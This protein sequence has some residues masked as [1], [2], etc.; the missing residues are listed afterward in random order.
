MSTA[1]DEGVRP[2]PAPARTALFFKVP[3]RSPRRILVVEFNPYQILAAE[4][5]RS[6]RGEFVLE[7]AAEFERGDTAGFSAWLEAGN[8]LGKYR[9]TAL[10]SLV[11]LR[12]IVQRENVQPAL[13]A[14]TGYLEELV[15][16]Q[17]KGRFLTATPF[18]VMRE[19]AWAFSTVNAVDG[20]PLPP[21]G[22][23]RPALVCAT[24]DSEVTEVQQLLSDHRLTRERIEPGL[25]SLFGAVYDGIARRGD[26]RAVVVIV[27]FESITAVY[28]LGKEGVHTPSPVLHGLNSIIEIARKELAA[29][30]D[31]DALAQLRSG[32]TFSTPMASRLVRRIARDLKP[33]VDS[34]EMTT[35]QPVDEIFCA[36]L[37]PTLQWL[38][39]PLARGTGRRAFALDRRDWNPATHFQVAGG[40]PAFG[41]HW[42]GALNLAAELPQC[43]GRGAKS[44]MRGGGPARPWHVDCSIPP[45]SDER[46]RFARRAVT[47]AAASILACVLGA[48]TGWQLYALNSLRADT[49]YWESQLAGNRRL[50]EELNAA[51][52]TLHRQSDLLDRAYDL[53]AEPFPLSELLVALGRTIPA[54]MRI[55]RIETNDTRVALSGALLEP[56]E[57][58]SGTLGR[59]M[60]ELRRDAAIG[61]LF[62]AIAIT[63]LQRKARSDEVT[64]ELTLRLNHTTP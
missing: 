57:E 20:T 16:E 31:A 48:A 46:D 3:R 7:A 26:V 38:T 12:G 36:Y 15:H 34:F 30:D 45:R 5:S 10:C 53:M 62:S 37:P 21:D 18:K 23:A 54:R 28:I 11:P 13:L 64:F 29:N 1:V 8:I 35:G 4:F 14:E 33:V 24:A 47:V 60:D 25:L 32:K 39:E 44:G 19:G 52:V 56:A 41:P 50:F 2:P 51:N 43:F 6:R 49:A 58:A 42:L 40:V 27:V 61:P 22:P 59:Y 55:E 17:Q 63:T 9:G